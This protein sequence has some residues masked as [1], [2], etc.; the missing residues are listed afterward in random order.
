MNKPQNML[1]DPL[2]Q[3]GSRELK[4]SVVQLVRERGRES[5]EGALLKPIAKQRN[6]RVM[7]GMP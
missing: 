2:S 4:L 5:L 3:L 7:A 6:R 1:T